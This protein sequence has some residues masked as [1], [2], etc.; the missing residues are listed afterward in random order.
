MEMEELFISGHPSN[1]S[2]GQMPVSI[3]HGAY[4]LRKRYWGVIAVFVG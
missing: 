2:S 4:V 3:K 1:A